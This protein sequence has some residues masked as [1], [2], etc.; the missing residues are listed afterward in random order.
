[1]NNGNIFNKVKLICVNISIAGVFF[2]YLP[3]FLKFPNT[4][5]FAINLCVFLCFSVFGPKYLHFPNALKC[6][7]NLERF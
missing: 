4:F 3:E 7:V 5:K 6:A 1:M 2:H